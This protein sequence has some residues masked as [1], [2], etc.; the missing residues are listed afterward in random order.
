[1]HRPPDSSP[2]KRLKTLPRNPGFQGGA[3]WTT[4]GKKRGLGGLSFASQ[5]HLPQDNSASVLKTGFGASLVVQWLRVCLAMEETQGTIPGS[6]RFH[7][8]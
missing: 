5:L 6:G 2:G 3:Q 4:T 8:N 7:S 1:M